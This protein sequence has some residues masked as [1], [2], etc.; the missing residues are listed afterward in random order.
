MA[1]FYPRIALFG[2]CSLE[3]T[4]FFFQI[5]YRCEG[6][7]VF[8]LLTQLPISVWVS[9]L[10]LP[11]SPLHMPLTCLSSCLVVVNFASSWIPTHKTLA[12]HSVV[13]FFLPSSPRALHMPSCLC[14]SELIFGDYLLMNLSISSKNSILNLSPTLIFLL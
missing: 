8:W 7:E 3:L 4:F 10:P 6:S 14:P 11:P 5:A 13:L 1:V 9:F 2:C 12:M